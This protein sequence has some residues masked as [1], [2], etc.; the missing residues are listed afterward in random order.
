MPPVPP[1]L[2]LSPRA[3]PN[4]P[5]AAVDTLN[6]RFRN[7]HPSND[8]DEV[9]III[10]QFDSRDDG[11]P[12]GQPWRPFQPSISSA[13]VYGQMGH[14]PDRDNVPVYS[15]SLAGL[16]LAP[17]HNQVRC[18]YAFDTGSLQWQPTACNSWRC[19]N[20][21]S[22]DSHA[23]GGCAFNPE[24]LGHMMEVQAEIRRRNYKPG[25]KVWDDHKFYNEV[26]M[27]EQTYV[28]NLPHSISAVFYLPT[29]CDDIFD[30]PKCE[31]FA[32]GA[33]RN[34]LRHFQLTEAQIPFVEFDYFNWNKPFTAM[35]NCDPQAKGVASCGPAANAALAR[36]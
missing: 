9:G 30:G 26:I 31:D 22:V 17:S 2:P 27:D 25:F 15:Y 4:A 21:E 33:H 24:G 8:L 14:E 7:G 18:S 28:A 12:D 35:P 1:S 10:H 20:Y 36:S 29:P 32:R 6:Q 19:S 34:I 16:I 23:N 11:D 3:P 13:I 5:F